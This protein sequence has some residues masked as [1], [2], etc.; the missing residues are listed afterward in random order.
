M[1]LPQT[2]FKVIIIHRW[3]KG[4]EG[5]QELVACPGITLEFLLFAETIFV[6]DKM[7]QLES[8]GHNI[9][10]GSEEP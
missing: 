6:D 5:Q 10:S 1:S 9:L 4:K 8:T 7:T 2:E 3:G